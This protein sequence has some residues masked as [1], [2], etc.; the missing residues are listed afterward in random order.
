MNRG[1]NDSQD[2]PESYLGQIYDEIAQCGIKLRSDD[3]ISKLAGSH[4][5]IPREDETVR[6]SS[7]ALKQESAVATGEDIIGA[8]RHL[9]Y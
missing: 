6:V 7:T 1:I 5:V 9:S 4:P 2:L 8:V 3:A